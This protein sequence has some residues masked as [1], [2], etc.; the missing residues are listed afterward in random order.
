[1]SYMDIQCRVVSGFYCIWNTLCEWNVNSTLIYNLSDS[2]PTRIDAVSESFRCQHR[3]D[4]DTVS[5]P[6]GLLS[7]VGNV[8][9]GIPSNAKHWE[10]VLWTSLE[11]SEISNAKV[12]SAD[13]QGL[14]QSILIHLTLNLLLMI[15]G[16]QTIFWGDAC[17][18][19]HL[20]NLLTLAN[21]QRIMLHW[22]WDTIVATDGLVPN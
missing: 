3:I 1:M 19:Y 10:G 11:A 9:D 8:L 6:V 7:G 2:G 13:S 5:V 21:V 4:I 17:F 22:T 15:D 14:I 16:K 18:L 12:I 20:D